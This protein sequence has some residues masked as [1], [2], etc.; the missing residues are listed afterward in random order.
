M[1][2]ADL[3]ARLALARPDPA[4]PAGK[5]D[6]GNL[7]PGFGG[8]AADE[9]AAFESTL[10]AVVGFIADRDAASFADR[11]GVVHAPQRERLRV[12]NGVEL[13]VVEAHL[14]VV[15]QLLAGLARQRV[16]DQLLP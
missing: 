9:A 13:I 11:L 2:G 3:A 16:V 5:L 12:G 1:R 4:A 8:R 10:A 14:D 7:L 15:L 6:A